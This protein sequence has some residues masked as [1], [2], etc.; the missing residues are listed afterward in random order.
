MSDNKRAFRGTTV[1]ILFALFILAQGTGCTPTGSPSL[2]DPDTGTTDI[3]RVGITPNA[4][5]L[6]YRRNGEITGLEAELARKLADRL[7]RKLRFVTLAWEKQIPALTAGKTDIIMSGMSI[8]E[9]RKY[10]ID[11]TKPYLV[12]GQVS[13]VRRDEFKR[14]DNG[15]S[16]LL[17]ITVTI[18]TV[19]ATTGSYLAE[20]RLSGT[21][22][23]EFS[24]PRQAISALKNK[25][26]DAFI[27]DLPMNFYFGALHE[28]E[29]LVP[30]PVPLSREHLAWGV[31]RSN[32]DLR[33]AAD[34]LVEELQN[35]GE[36]KKMVH[37]WI[38]FY[39]NL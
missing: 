31:S 17:N 24:T 38:P 1:S 18:G 3:L 27:Y 7:G 14:F 12:S 35:S 10:R 5:P 2:S 32:P 26:I 34:A 19:T 15:L 6:I 11:F 20:K 8:T 29:G 37:H 13:L 28:A 22:K 16:D 33:T 30:V 21:K 4:P 36:L 9:L 25:S 23:K 39:R